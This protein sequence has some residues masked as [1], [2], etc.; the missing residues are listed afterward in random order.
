[1]K[2]ALGGLNPQQIKAVKQIKGPVLVLAGAGS[3]KTKT[4]TCRIAYLVKE[5]KIAPENI[6]AITFTNKAAGEILQRV[7]RTVGLRSDKRF[8]ISTFHSFCARLLRHE[9]DKLGYSRNFSIL[10]TGN[11]LTATKQAME[12]LHL[13][14]QKFAPEAILHHISSAKNELIGADAYSEIAKGSFQKVVASVYFIYQEILQ[15]NQAM[16][17]DDLIINVVKLFKEQPDVLAKYQKRFQYIL[18]DE[19]Q[20][21]NTAQYEL[22]NLLASK[23]RNL[24]V[25]GDDWQSIYSWRGANFRN[26]LNFNKDYPDAKVFKLEQN[27]RSTQAILDAGHAVIASNKSKSSKKLWT[28]QSEGDPIVVYEALNEKDESD[29][30][31]RE[32]ARVQAETGAKLSDF[33]VLYRTNAQSRSLEEGALRYGVPYQV[34]GGVRFYERKE[35]KDMLAYLTLL[36]NPDDSLALQRVINVPARGIGKRTWAALESVARRESKSIYSLLESNTDAPP[37]AQDFTKVLNKIKQKS[38]TLVLSKLLDYILLHSGYKKMLEGEGIEGETRLENIFEL[39]SVMEKYDHLDHQEALHTFL[40]EVSLISDI[41]TH[42]DEDDTLTFMTLHSSKGLEFDYV[43]ITGLEENIFPHSRSLMEQDELEE[44]RRLCYVG[45]TRA[46]KRIYL[47]YV[48]ERLLYGLVQTNPPSRFIEDLPQDLIERVYRKSRHGLV[49]L[50]S[51]S[52]SIQPG[53]RI[54]HKKFGP[55]MVISKTGETLTIAFVKA[56]IKNLDGELADLKITK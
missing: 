45:I 37:G 42:K 25:V 48:E 12:Q 9:A 26:I 38:A 31:F 22:A 5:K 6:L 47:T 24:F 16:D 18:I 51:R 30:I 44:E 23:H 13:D 40:E 46:R 21:T 35:I 1:M 33:V 3:G 36:T 29:F 34:V 39:K 43:F 15:H 8:N 53:A 19:Y 7:R 55:G 49:G 50:H 28:D 54:V 14:A 4:L 10:D 2:S 17:F 20:D 41:D 32:I 52:K 27:Y 56:G 11:S